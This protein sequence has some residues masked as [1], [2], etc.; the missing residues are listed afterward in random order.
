MPH[1][2][3]AKFAVESFDPVVGALREHRAE[4]AGVVLQTDRFFDQPDRAFLN[5][6][7]GLRLREVE[8]VDAHGL[9]IDARPMV[10]F[11]GPVKEGRLKVRREIQTRL[12]D[13]QAA[14]K[15]L[16]ACGL[17]CVQTLQKRRASYRLGAC[18]VELDLLPLIGSFVEIEGPDE[19]TI[20]ALASELGIPG[21]HLSEPYVRLAG[22]RARELG[23]DPQR[24]V[25]ED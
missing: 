13:A 10:T 9:A 5:N 8:V 15:L 24:V 7:C 20:D 19:E 6:G 22:D 23:R 18:S 3:E 14:R 21:P 4:P 17:Q 16:L 2:V 11:K 1:E 25:F 12:D